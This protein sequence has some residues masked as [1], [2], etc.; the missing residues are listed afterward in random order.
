[1]KAMTKMTELLFSASG[2]R[3]SAANGNT[4]RNLFS[5]KP[6]L[7]SAP[8]AVGLCCV[9]AGCSAMTSVEPTSQVQEVRGIVHGG[10]QPVTGATIRLIAP[11]TAGYGSAGTAIA[12]TTTDGTGSFTLPSYTCPANSGLVYILATGGNPGAGTNSSL[13]EAAV[14]GPCSGLTASTF[15]SISEV[16]TVA[17]AYTLAPFAS[18]SPGTTNIGTSATNLIGLKNAAAPAGNLAS[19]ATGLAGIST[20]GITLPTAEVN[21][22]ADILSAC[23]NSGTTGVASTTCSSLF[24]AATPPGGTAPTDTFQAAI[25]IALNPGNNS[26]SL[27]ALST[28]SAPYQPTLTTNPGDFALG[29]VYT[30]G[31]LGLAAQPQGIDIDAQGNVWVAVANCGSAC[32]GAVSGLVEVSPSGVV[33]PSTGVYLSAL[34]NPQAVAIT[35]GGVVEVADYDYGVYAYAPPGSTGA[36][37]TNFATPSV[38]AANPSGLAVDNRDG[39]T[40]ITNIGNNTITH[41]SQSGIQLTASSPLGTGSAPLGVGI[42]AS[43][44]IVIADSDSLGAG[45]LSSLTEYLPTGTGTYTGGTVS[46]VPGL[47]PSDVAFDNAGDIWVSVNNGAIEYTSGGVAISPGAGYTSNPG[48]IADSISI[49]GLGRAFVSNNTSSGV[50]PGS[51]TVFANNGTLISTANSNFG[52]RANGAIMVDPFIPK[53]LAIDAS[54]NCWI[55]GNTPNALTELIGIAAPVATPLSVQNTPTNQLGVRP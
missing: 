41:I 54:G 24:T 51:L 26:A 48:N 49:D 47:Y 45:T 5:A 15:I 30:G 3:R 18:L 20:T 50:T 16:T 53:G 29:I 7:L 1:M 36:G 21:T 43:D 19:V 10:Q 32:R 34:L 11:G 9:L 23:V 40:W 4:P 31:N 44:D 37:F 6:E 35:S 28:P 39:S 27:F 22:L 8:I 12:S 42:T 46:T 55:A 52:Y 2:F 38:S 17:A 33:S 25:D 13:A 14:L